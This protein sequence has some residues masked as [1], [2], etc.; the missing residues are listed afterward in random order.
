MRQQNPP[1]TPSSP[2]TKAKKILPGGCIFSKYVQG[3][4]MR[5][6][7]GRRRSL[8]SVF[9]QLSADDDTMNWVETLLSP[10]THGLHRPYRHMVIVDLLLTLRGKCASREEEEDKKKKSVRE[11]SHDERLAEGCA[12]IWNIPHGS[13][14]RVYQGRERLTCSL[15]LR[16]VK[17]AGRDWVITNRNS[18]LGT[19][20]SNIY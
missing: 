15:T 16:G 11:W 19:Q 8:C 7:G 2:Q 10:V 14:S 4:T 17:A 13:D 18:P 20:E 5:R 3:K 12:Q 9:L 6:R 1:E